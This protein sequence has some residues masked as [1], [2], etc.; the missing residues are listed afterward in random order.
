MLAHPRSLLSELW[1]MVGWRLTQF[2]DLTSLVL[3]NRSANE[4]ATIVLYRHVVLR[5]HA[6][7][8][9]MMALLAQ[10]PTSFF[11]RNV[12]A[13][14]VVHARS[15]RKPVADSFEGWESSCCFLT[16]IEARGLLDALTDALRYARIIHAHPALGQRLLAHPRFVGH[17]GGLSFAP[18]F[19]TSRS[20]DPRTLGRRS[21]FDHLTWVL[22]HEYG[23]S[24]WVLRTL[25]TVKPPSL[26]IIVLAFALFMA[27]GVHSAAALESAS[28]GVRRLDTV[29]RVIYVVNGMSPS[30]VQRSDLFLCLSKTG[31][32]RLMM[33]AAPDGLPD[34]ERAWTWLEPGGDEEG[35]LRIVS[36]CA[37]R[38][39]GEGRHEG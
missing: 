9:A 28:R 23:S 38:P 18:G 25:E 10:K 12:R 32:R 39:S 3:V 20:P 26:R 16:D 6:G 19:D 37:G 29:R 5:S 30:A 36:A 8:E 15:S 21:A 1:T 31:D 4:G 13:L 33:I 22:I 35:S 7:H 34:D 2:S 14:S 24:L 11:N 17:P 27:R